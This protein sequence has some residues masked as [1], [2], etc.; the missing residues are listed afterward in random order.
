MEYL[1][2]IGIQKSTYL[3]GVMAVRVKSLFELCNYLKV[4]F[5]AG[6][7]VFSSATKYSSTF[8]KSEIFIGKYSSEDVLCS[9][10]RP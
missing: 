2:L 3:Y 9:L 5:A 10:V 6:S 7:R 8:L 1:Q 4:G